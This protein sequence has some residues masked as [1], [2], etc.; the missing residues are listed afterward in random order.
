MDRLAEERQAVGSALE[1]DWPFRVANLARNL[2]AELGR[3]GV[4]V[5]V[6]DQ[7]IA[8]AE[9]HGCEAVAGASRVG[10]QL[11]GA[12]VARSSNGLRLFSPLD[13]V[14]SIL[15][16]DGVLATGTQIARTVRAARHAGAKR[17]VAAA[18]LANHEAIDICRAEIDGDVIALGEF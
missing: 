14:E 16:L 10:G 2:E 6:A 17:A 4:L 13:P 12:L 18:V 8:I 5:E 1:D 15:V 7:L 9:E 3:P 11:A